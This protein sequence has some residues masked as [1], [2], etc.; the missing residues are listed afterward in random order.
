MIEKSAI[1]Y[2]LFPKV[3]LKFYKLV[4]IFTASHFR[5]S[6]YMSQLIIIIEHIGTIYLRE[7][8]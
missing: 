6:S 2:E 4:Y 5:I 1:W 3:Y 7:S 8:K